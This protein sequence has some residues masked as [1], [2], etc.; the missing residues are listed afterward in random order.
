MRWPW[1]WPNDLDTQTWPRYKMLQDV[2]PYQKWSFYVNSFKSYSP[3]R[4]THTHT[5]TMKTL[6][7]PHM[8]EVKRADKSTI[9]LSTILLIISLHRPSETCNLL[10]SELISLQWNRTEN[11]FPHYRKVWFSFYYNWK[12]CTSLL[13]YRYNNTGMSASLIKLI[14]SCLSVTQIFM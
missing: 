1:P 7:L 3:N 8:G 4:H 11:Y 12:V 14:T 5:H 13:M 6:P 2:T 10:I 9:E